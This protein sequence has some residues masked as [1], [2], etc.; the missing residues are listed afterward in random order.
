MSRKQIAGITILLIALVSIGL[1]PGAQ[2]SQKA[3]NEEPVRMIITGVPP[4]GPTEWTD[5]EGNTVPAG[6]GPEAAR[7]LLAY[8]D[9]RY[10][11][12][13]LVRG[14]PGKAIEELH[15]RMHTTTVVW[16][17]DKQ[18]FT[19]PTFFKS[20]L[21]SYIEARYPSGVT[22]KTKTGSL[23][24]VFEKSVELIK[25]NKPHIILF[26]W[27]GKTLIFP[28]HYSVVVGYSMEADR[29]ELIINTGWG[30]DF[31]ILDMTDSAVAP[32]RLYWIEEIKDPPDGQAGCAIGPSSAQGMWV[33]DAN[34]K[35]QLAPILHKHFD[36]DNT[37]SWSMSDRTNF[38]LPNS[39]SKI[40]ACYWY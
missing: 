25:A 15:D 10:G 34:G 30:Y 37:V 12:K 26:D 2:T 20:G 5:D 39:G 35:Y 31:Q 33:K 17:G 7:M 32:A 13:Q 29:K 14:H 21:K 1:V 18:G 38:F 11:Y 16:Q 27:E 6:C 36:P 28:N 9:S 3:H 24:S 4:F 19:D 8:Y 40:G 23:N 22:I